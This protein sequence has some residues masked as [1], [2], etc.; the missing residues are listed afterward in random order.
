MTINWRAVGI[1]F[2]VTL[3]AGVVAGFTVPVADLSLSGASWVVAGILGGAAAG[4]VADAGRRT[5]A[6]HGALATTIGAL[7]VLVVLGAAGS[8]LAAAI[9][10]ELLLVSLLL[11]G[12]YAIPGAIGGWVGAMAKRSAEEPSEMDAGRPAGR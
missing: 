11:L 7:A 9:G 3:L 4:Y 2:V 5:G 1:G 8:F 6:A 10:L 12:L